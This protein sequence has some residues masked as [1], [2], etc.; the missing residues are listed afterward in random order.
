M[1]AKTAANH[2]IFSKNVDKRSRKAMTDFLSG[3]FRYST[4]S[5]WNH[6]TSYACNMKIHNL[7]L[8]YETV[9]KLYDMLRVPEFFDGIDGLIRQ[10]GE[11]HQ[12]RWQAGWNGRSGGYL[13]LYQGVMKNSEHRSYCT[14]CGQKN[15]RSVAETGPR[16][17]VCSEDTRVDYLVPPK[18]V[19]IYPGRSTDMNED[20]EDWTLADLRDRTE[21][22]QEFDRLAD[23]IVSEGLYMAENKTVVERTIYVPTTELVFA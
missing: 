15:F 6:S 17:G 2:H 10:F 7:G 5:S 9:D 1:T 8:D 23:D 18:Q 20:F 11:R 13:V 19:M 14:N 22:V 3:H 12:F 4:N 21:L 16:C